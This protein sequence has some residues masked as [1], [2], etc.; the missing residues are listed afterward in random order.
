MEVDGTGEEIP[1]T[2]A[3]YTVL[4]RFADFGFQCS[5]YSGDLD[6]TD[7]APKFQTPITLHSGP[8]EFALSVLTQHHSNED[9]AN[10]KCHDCSVK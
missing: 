7:S 3:I 9:I 6:L 4:I 2:A 10:G 5:L 1:A 8:D